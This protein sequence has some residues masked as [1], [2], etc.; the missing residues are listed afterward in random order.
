M[1][2]TATVNPAVYLGRKNEGIIKKDAAANLLLLDAN[3]LE[4]VANTLQISGVM[5]RGKWHTSADIDRARSS[6]VTVYEN[7]W[8]WSGSGFVRG[9]LAI[10]E[11]RFVDILEAGAGSRRVDLKGGFVVPPYSNAHAPATT[12]DEETSHLFLEA[13]VFYVWNPNTVVMGQEALNFFKRK[14]TFDVAVAQGGLT[15]PGGH[16]EKLY[17]D[18]LA[19]FSPKYKGMK[20]RDFLGNA[21]H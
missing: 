17:V 7:G 1:L 15:E 10:K 12:P 14:D 20:L 6:G 18:Q 11:G 4:D 8:V 19:K 13:G 9:S 16:P 21:F 3:P 5:L 2:K